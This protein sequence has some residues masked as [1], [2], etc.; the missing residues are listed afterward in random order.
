MPF[1]SKLDDQE[2][3]QILKWAKEG[4]GYTEI[5]KLLDNRISR[6]R[7]KQ[8]CQRYNIDAFTIKRQKNLEVL[9]EKMVSKWGNKWKDKDHRRSYIYQAMREKFRVKKA[10]A[11]RVGYD[12]TIE[13]GDLD[14]P[15]HCPVLGIAI[16]YFNTVIQDNSP[17]FDRV[18][19]N[20]GYVK[21]NVVIISKRANT[22]KSNGTAEEHLKVANYMRIHATMD[23]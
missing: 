17:S 11:I 5:A 7:V 2:R 9:E 23:C 18:D 8:I 3:Q 12:W 21:G 16:D 19:S 15:T 10:N 6:Q 20:K 22:I 1:T 14:F 13:F 4:Q